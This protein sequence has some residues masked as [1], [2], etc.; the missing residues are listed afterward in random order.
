MEVPTTE[1]YVRAIEGISTLHGNMEVL[2]RIDALL[3]DQNSSLDDIEKLLETDGALS[4]SVIKL[5]NRAG[6]GMGHECE[7]VYDALQ[8]VGFSQA[9]R[10]VSSALSKQVFM[11]DLDAYGISASA[12]WKYSYFTANFMELQAERAELDQNV[13]YLLGLL[14]SIGRVVVNELLLKSEIEVF[15]DR[16]ILPEE[17]ETATIGFTSEKAGALLLKSW[18]FAEPIYSRVEKQSEAIEISGDPMLELLDYARLV[19]MNIEDS[20]SI[21]KLCSD[22]EHPFRRDIEMTSS[23]VKSDIQESEN[24]VNEILQTLKPC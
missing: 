21:E 12:Y 15:W 23:D 24:A 2:S 16:S 10:L 19:A 11:R 13:A 8:T 1:S 6:L 22:T 9:I 18:K 5:S 20:A 17:W 3:K 7:S 4:A 14:H